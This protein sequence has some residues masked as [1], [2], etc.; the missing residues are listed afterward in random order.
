MD[1]NNNR[2][3]N[4]VHTES[5]PAGRRKYF[6]DIRTTREGDYY[7]TITERK[8]GQRRTIH[9]YKEDFVKFENAFNTCAKKIRELVPNFDDVQ[10]EKKEY[11]NEEFQS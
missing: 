7:L 9:L 3:D 1:Y 5:V 11:N 4:S 8:E 2:R 6:L 10:Y